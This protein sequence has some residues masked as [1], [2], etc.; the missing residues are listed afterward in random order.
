MKTYIF[1]LAYHENYFFFTYFFFS[2]LDLFAEHLN[3][4]IVN[5]KI[6]PNLCHGFSDT[7]PIVRESTIKVSPYKTEDP[8]A[9]NR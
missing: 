6:F 3:T 2:Q 4:G 8:L 5:D 1:K 7:N 9:I